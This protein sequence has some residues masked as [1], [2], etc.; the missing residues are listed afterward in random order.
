MTSAL[1]LTP[2]VWLGV[3][4]ATVGIYLLGGLWFTP[5]FGRAWDRGV[6]VSRRPGERFGLTYYVVPLVGAAGAAYALAF[7]V[8]AADVAAVGD[9]LVLGV[10]VGVGVGLTVSF[11]NALT[12]RTARPLLY[13]LVTGCYH[14]VSAVVAAVVAVAA[15]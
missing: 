4:G 7:L 8:V 11:T 3:L 9:A 10:V 6:G 1:S 15:R 12:P 5:M 14:V 13:G 2:S